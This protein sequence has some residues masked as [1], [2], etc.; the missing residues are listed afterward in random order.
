MGSGFNSHHLAGD[1][2]VDR[3]GDR[4]GIFAYLLAHGD[5]LAHGYR[6]HTGRTYVL[7]H[8]YDYP[9]RRRDHSFGHIRRL[10]VIGM[11]AAFE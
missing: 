3:C 2:G 11:H 4:C 7:S 8:G 1:G 6:R 9:G 10:H 5:I